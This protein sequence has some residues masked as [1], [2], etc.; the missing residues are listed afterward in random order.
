[1]EKQLPIVPSPKPGY[2]NHPLPI[3]DPLRAANGQILPG[4]AVDGLACLASVVILLVAQPASLGPLPNE[5]SFELG[6][7]AQNVEQ[8]PR[9]EKE[10]K[11]SSKWA[12]GRIMWRPIRL[13]GALFSV[14]EV[15]ILVR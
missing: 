4:S 11:R 2:A 1:M 12:N 10:I 5:G 15:T 8:E 14:E 9:M 6:R 13:G 3:E 7:G